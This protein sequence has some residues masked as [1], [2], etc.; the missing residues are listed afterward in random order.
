MRRNTAD[1]INY[2]LAE[3][4]VVALIFFLTFSTD[5]PFRRLNDVLL[6]RVYNAGRRKINRLAWLQIREF[7]F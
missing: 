5:C 1:K 6:N 7:Y 2:G 3:V 4:G